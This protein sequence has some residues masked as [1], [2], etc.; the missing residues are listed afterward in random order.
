[1]EKSR[2]KQEEEN[3]ENKTKRN[4]EARK[5]MKKTRENMHANI[6]EKKRRLNYN[7]SVLFGPIFICSCCDRKLFENGVTKI[8]SD[9]KEKVNKKKKNFY[10]IC[11]RKET[12]V[13]VEL[14]GKTDKTGSYI[15]GTCKAALLTGNVPSM[16]RING[17]FLSPLHE[18]YYL[19][20]LEN[21]MIAQNIN[22]QY[23]FC[24]KKSRWA[25]TKKKMISVPVTTDTINNT[26]QQLPRLP[27]EAGLIEVGI[28]RKN[29]YKH[30]HK[31]EL[32]DVNKIFMVLEHLKASGH[33]YYQNFENFQAYKKRCEDLDAEGHE[34]LFGEEDMEINKDNETNENGEEVCSVFMII[35]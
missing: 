32:I 26:L 3:P 25:A 29:E 15:C 6:D 12:T 30:C 28:K 7:L 21:N 13:K 24:L 31:Q 2:K 4:E 1:M 19:T 33:P 16:A 34:M 23:I 5:L 14:N 20:E 35:Y 22:F 8:T 18:Q 11:I 9:F 27:S 10:N 17:L